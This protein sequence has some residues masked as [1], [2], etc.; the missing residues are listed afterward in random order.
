MRTNRNLATAGTGRITAPIPTTTAR[1]ATEASA[2]GARGSQRRVSGPHRTGPPVSAD[3]LRARQR[4]WGAADADQG[5]LDLRPR[6]PGRAAGQAAPGGAGRQGR[7]SVAGAGRP[8]PVPGAQVE[9]E[10]IGSR[11]R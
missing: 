4:V 8:P 3:G 11:R 9:G 2:D 5:P 6:T 7:P 10:Q 1:P